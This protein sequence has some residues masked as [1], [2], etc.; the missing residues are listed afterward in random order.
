MVRRS[1]FVCTTH[2]TLDTARWEHPMAALQ[3]GRRGGCREGR[4]EGGWREGRREDGEREGGRM[5]RGKEGGRIEGR[6]E[7]R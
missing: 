7:D 1:S 5:D 3:G 6:R 2:S 4:K